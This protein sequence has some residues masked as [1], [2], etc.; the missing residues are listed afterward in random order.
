MDSKKVIEILASVLEISETEL[1]EYDNAA[2]LEEKGF[3]S[4]KFIKTV[5]LLED[6]FNIE[7]NDSDLLVSNFATLGDVFKTLDKYLSQ[8]NV[9][10][11]VLVTDCDYVLWSGISGE[12]QLSLNSV[13]ITFQN[14]LVELYN[15]GVL[16]CLCSKNEQSNIDEAF[17]TLEMPLKNEHILAKKINRTNKATNI[18]ELASELNLSTD[19]FVFVDDSDYELG[20]ISSLIPD[21]AVVKADLSNADWINRVK[22][23]FIPGIGVEKRTQQYREQMERERDKNYF[24]SVEEYNESFNTKVICELATSEQVERIAELSQRTNQFNLAVSRYSE[25]DISELIHNANY[26]VIMLSVDDK[27]GDMGIIGCAIVRLSERAVIEAFMLSCRAF[28]RCFE[29]VLLQKVK[30]ITAGKKLYGILQRNEKNKRYSDFY[31]NNGVE[32]V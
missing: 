2:P 30:S 19:S 12:E 29:F 15:S 24:T 23:M 9:F 5:V 32:C 21:I 7:I 14:L 10:K 28:D 20:L 22:S 31:K 8:K 6:E 17:N 27:Y 3:D 11:K 1:N 16:I 26:A 25:H 18:R 13:C 4:I